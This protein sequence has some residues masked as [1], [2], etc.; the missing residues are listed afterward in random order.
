MNIYD[1]L[2]KDHRRFESLLDQL[3]AASKAGDEKWKTILDELRRDLIAHAHAEE[4]V[5]YNALREADKSKM[6]VAHSYAEHGMAEG[7]IRT[8]SV[9]KAIDQEWTG[10]AQKLSESLRHHIEEEETKVYDAA[11]QVFDTQDAEQIG[12]AFERMKVETAKDGDSVMASTVD[13]IANLLPPKWGQ[14]FRKN[15]SAPR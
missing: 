15:I 12:A 13:L 3:I 2:S 7:Q 8:L 4:A 1:A 9:A 11:R 5:F 6:L 14:A 10:L